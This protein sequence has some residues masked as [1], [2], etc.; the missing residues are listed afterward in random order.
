MIVTGRNGNLTSPLHG[1]LENS[2]LLTKS[3]TTPVKY[4]WYSRQSVRAQTFASWPLKEQAYKLS[5]AGF[6]S[7]RTTIS[8]K[9]QNK[10]FIVCNILLAVSDCSFFCFTELDDLVRCFQCGVGL[11]NWDPEDEPWVEHARWMPQ[12]PFVVANTSMEFIERVQEAVRQNEVCY[13]KL[14]NVYKK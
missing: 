13:N 11:R 14:I 5:E 8:Y 12:C 10:T 4:P 7:P 6:F 9:E 1:Y 3:R 2:R